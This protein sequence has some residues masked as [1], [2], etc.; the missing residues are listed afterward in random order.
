MIERKLQKNII[1]SLANFPAVGIIG[2][3]QVG[4][5]TLVKEVLKGYKI[6]IYLDLELPSDLV[7]LE[8][9]EFFFTSFKSELVVIDEIQRLPKLFP[10]LRG[11]IDK[12]KKERKYILL[13]SASPNLLRSSSESLAGRI[14]YHELMP[15][16]FSEISKQKEFTINNFWLKGGYPLS[17]LSDSG[18]NAFNWLNAF[19]QT[20]LERD[21]PQLGINIPAVQLRKFWTMLAHNHGQLWNASALAKG[22]GITAPTV[23]NYLDIL[24][25]TFIVRQL[26]PY[27]SNVKK[28]LVK[29]P[30][31]YLRDTGLLHSILGINTFESLLSHPIV[32]FSW[33]GF[34]IEEII[35]NF[36]EKFEYYFYRSQAGAEIDLI[37]TKGNI[38]KYLVEI[39]N[40][41]SPKLSRS[42]S[43]AHQDFD[44]LQ[45][46]VIYPGTEN[47][48]IRKNVEVISITGL[49]ELEL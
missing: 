37:L 39:K 7:K 21:I 49:L 48:K 19:V 26:Q 40:S 1:N 33:E 23:R 2:P 45:S 46:F 17:F 47:Y 9:P 35:K 16:S 4:K 30:K 10:I 22:L 38:P 13:G 34:V 44:E 42:F 28:R 6:G 5:T 20:F 27:H 43:I 24:T 14:K 15:F 32:G 18:E 11:I 12:E 29:S 3:R 36:G 41:L 31:V 25:E 8:D